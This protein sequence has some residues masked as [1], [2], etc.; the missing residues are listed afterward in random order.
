VIRLVVTVP[1]EL[2]QQE[3]LERAA[4]SALDAHAARDW[5]VSVSPF[6]TMPGCLLE[7]AVGHLIERRLLDTLGSGE[8]ERALTQIARRADS[9]DEQVGHGLHR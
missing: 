1:L 5:T 3:A 8:L 7:V 6:L 4:H 2:P 9:R